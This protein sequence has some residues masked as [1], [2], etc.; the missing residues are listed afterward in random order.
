MSRKFDRVIMNPP[1]SRDTH[2]KILTKVL[3]YVDTDN[4]GQIVNLSPTRWLEDPLV[5]HKPTCDYYKYSKIREK[6][7]DIIFIPREEASRLFGGEGTMANTS[8]LGIYLMGNP[9]ETYETEEN[10]ILKK[11][12]D[13]GFYGIPYKRYCNKT[14]PNYVAINEM[15]TDGGIGNVSVKLRFIRNPNRYGPFI[16]DRYDGKTLEEIKKSDTHSTRGTTEG[17]LIVEFETETETRNFYSFC[18]MDLVC[19]ITAL[20]TI[21]RHFQL[22]YIPY[23]R[24]YT[25][26]WTDKDLY[27]FY[28]ITEEEQKEIRRYIDE[29]AD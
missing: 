1:Y 15:I 21:G 3:N 8:N 17:S 26:E 25:R 27:D 4:G 16:N 29:F 14:Y 5:S 12:L 13:S 7:E 28:G 19:Y 23:V 18:N 2:L 10:P 11:I 22:N 6:M 20:T 24:D 9:A